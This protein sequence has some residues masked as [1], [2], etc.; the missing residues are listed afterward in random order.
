MDS[1]TPAGSVNQLMS[2]LGE[3]KGPA[4]KPLRTVIMPDYWVRGQSI[5]WPE[6]GEG[7]AFN[8]DAVI[9]PLFIGSPG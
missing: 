5:R 7:D 2:I 6:V 8:E 4:R 1:V 3:S 9:W